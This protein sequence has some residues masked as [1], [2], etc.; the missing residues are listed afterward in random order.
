MIYGVSCLS[1]IGFTMS[2]FISNL[3]FATDIYEQEA[4]LGILVASLLSG[5][6]GTI[7]LMTDKS[8]KQ[9]KEKSINVT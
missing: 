5:I 7:V 6:V 9:V 1:G 2:L 3:A 8:D 4:K